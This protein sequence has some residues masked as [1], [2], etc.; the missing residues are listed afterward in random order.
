[1]DKRVEVYNTS[2]ADVNGKCGVALDF[3]PVRDGQGIVP[4]DSRYRVHLDSGELFKLKVTAVRAEGLAAVAP[5]LDQSVE[6]SGG[7]LAGRRGVA[8]DFILRDGGWFYVVPLEV[9]GRSRR[10]LILPEHLRVIAKKTGGK[11]KGRR[12]GN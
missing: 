8:G 5:L 11:K 7:N 1:M 9:D 2:R 10:A 3:H 6:I 4:Q 12:A